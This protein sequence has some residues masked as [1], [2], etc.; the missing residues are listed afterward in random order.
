MYL[1]LKERSDNKRKK[2]KLIRTELKET[3]N[4]IKQFETG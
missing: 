2:L 3:R 4:K 1:K